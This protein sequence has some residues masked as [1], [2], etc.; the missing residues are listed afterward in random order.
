MNIESDVRACI[1][2]SKG[3]KEIEHGYIE[4]L[5]AVFTQAREDF[6]NGSPREKKQII[7]ELK[8]PE[9]KKMTLGTSAKMAERLEV[10][11]AAK[12]K[13]RYN[14]AR[15]GVLRTLTAFVLLGLSELCREF[16]ECEEC[17]FSDECSGEVGR[18]DMYIDAEYARDVSRAAAKRYKNLRSARDGKFEV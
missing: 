10:M 16:G 18:P 12:D 13:F 2:P 6:K 15:N 17:P 5:K 8:S 11:E 4:L 7:E 1:R 9:I 14:D 3:I